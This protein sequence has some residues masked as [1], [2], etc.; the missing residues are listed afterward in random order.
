MAT[1]PDEIHYQFLKHL[2]KTFLTILQI[3]NDIWWSNYFPKHWLEV[4]IIPISKPGKDHSNPTNYRPIVLTSFICKTMERIVNA[5]LIWCLE[6]HNILSR[7]QNRFRQNQGTND[8]LIRL[9]T[10]NCNGLIKNHHVASI[11]FDLSKSIWYN[12]EIW[13]PKRPP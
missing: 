1:G 5:W 8:K 6:K 7:Y 13:N 12:M 10:C 2:S 9:K 3:F 11:F 4:F